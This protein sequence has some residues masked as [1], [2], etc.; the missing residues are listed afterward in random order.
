MFKAYT[1]FQKLKKVM[2]GRSISSTTVEGDYFRDKLTP[3]TKRLLTQLLDETEEDYQNLIRILEKFDVEVIRPEY[4]HEDTYTPYLMNPRDDLIV[5]D[6][7]LV[8]TQEAT[9]TSIDYVHPLIEYKNK[10][11]RN[12]HTF[13]LMPPSIV[14]LGNDII[15]DKQEL[16]ESNY[17]TSTN[18][19]KEWL[20]PLGYNIIYTPTHNFQFKAQVSH[21]D[22][23]LSLQK[24]GVLLTCITQEKYTQN[25]FKGWDACQVDNGFQQMRKWSSFKNDNKAYAF[26][27]EKYLDASWNKLITSWLEDWVGYAK[28]TVFD[29]NCL[30]IDEEHVIVSNYNKE[31]FDF[32]KKHKIE[33]IISPWRHRYFWDGGIH[34]I[35][36]DLEREGEREQYL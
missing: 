13:G 32:F 21:A 36:V 15:V 18:Y 30:S 24:P 17:E 28:E 11:K 31:V 27:D 29:V 22:S 8:C 7:S 25:I 19:L 10:I 33:P 5:L 4:Y 16:Q 3:T 23:V 20:E 34:C 26:E 12:K 14:R 1:E 2:V 9:L 6:D 35:T